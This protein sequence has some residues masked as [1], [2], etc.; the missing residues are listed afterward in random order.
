[1]S[2]RITHSELVEAFRRVQQR[3]EHTKDLWNDPVRWKF[4]KDHWEPLEKE[5]EVTL[6]EMERLADVLAK[7]RRNVRMP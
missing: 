7:A 2:L 1:M 4:E 6:G 3:W 5:T